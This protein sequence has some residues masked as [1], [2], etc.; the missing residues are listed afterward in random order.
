MYVCTWVSARRVVRRA[1]TR[2]RLS[3]GLC[4]AAVR[5][6]SRVS[7]DSRHFATAPVTARRDPTFTSRPDDT[8]VVCIH[9]R[10]RDLDTLVGRVLSNR[11][12]LLVLPRPPLPHSLIYGF[13]LGNVRNLSDGVLVALTLFIHAQL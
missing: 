7:R 11:A 5:R 8:I 12:L 2:T 4:H 13:S 1:K 3:Q 10:L 9:S 6:M